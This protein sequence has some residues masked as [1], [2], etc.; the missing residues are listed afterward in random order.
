VGEVVAIGWEDTTPGALETF[1]QNC[2]VPDTWMVI[3]E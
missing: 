3:I 2:G 1:L